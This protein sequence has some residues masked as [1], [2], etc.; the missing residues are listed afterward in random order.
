MTVEPVPFHLSLPGSDTLG[1]SG[2][3]SASYRVR[4]L[5]HLEGG[6][7]TFEWSVLKHVEKVTLSGVEER[8]EASPPE[9]LDVPA[10]WVGDAR[11]V[12]GW[13]WPRLV[14]RGRRLDAF[15]GVPGATPGFVAL[16]VARRDR[17]LA[18]AMAAAILEV[19]AL[20]G[21]G[22]P[23]ALAEGEMTPD[24]GTDAPR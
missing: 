23:E 20:P 10:S 4:G 24:R 21:A 19:R 13:W 11:L 15:D 22:S 1:L 3:R 2:A 18:A 7:L 8:D 16:R 12:G 6:I 9:L 5:L 17:P 14:L